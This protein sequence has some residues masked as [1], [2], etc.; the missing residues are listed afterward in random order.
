MRQKVGPGFGQGEECVA[1]YA[2]AFRFLT[3][4]IPLMLTR[5][6]RHTRT[7][8]AIFNLPLLGDPD[9]HGPLSTCFNS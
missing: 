7:R 2:G 1:T 5:M 3:R 6:H 8:E 4:P 9:S